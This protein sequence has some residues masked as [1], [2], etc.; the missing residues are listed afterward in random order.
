[1]ACTAL[2]PFKSASMQVKATPQISVFCRGVRAHMRT[3][4]NKSKI[5]DGVRRFYNTDLYRLP[6]KSIYPL[7]QKRKCAS[8]A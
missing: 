6:S 5:E 3:G 1:M 8:V 2:L 7:I 4:A